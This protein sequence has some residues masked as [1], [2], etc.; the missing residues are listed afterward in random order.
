MQDFK[1][2]QVWQMPHQ[3][4]LDIYS[5]TRDFPSDERFGLTSQ[6]RRAS[7]S[8][9]ANL[10]EGCS[11]GSD[12]D[13]ARFVQ[14]ATGPASEVNYHLLLA[15]D[16]GYLDAQTYGELTTNGE[17]VKRMLIALLKRLRPDS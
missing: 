14:I 13:F 1:N 4:T 9:A 2:L 3:M 5:A 6:L 17:S 7:A 8:I 15:K 16:L 10:A 11:R 12:S